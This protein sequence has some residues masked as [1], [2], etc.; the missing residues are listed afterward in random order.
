MF[1]RGPRVR[2]ARALLA[3]RELLAATH[4]ARDVARVRCGRDRE[5]FARIAALGLDTVRSFLLW[6]DFPPEPDASI[7][8]CRSVLPRS[9][10][11]RAAPGFASCPCCAAAARRNVRVPAW[12]QSA[13][14]VRDLYSGPMLDAQ[15]AFARA[16]GAR[17]ASIPPCTRG[18][19]G[20]G[21]RRSRSRRACARAPAITR[22]RSS[23]KRR[24]RSG[25]A[26]SPACSPRRPRSAP[27][28]GRTRR[29]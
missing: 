9:P 15:L 6:D 16:V 23:R 29:I 17:C 2:R 3:G 5:D 4:V 10:M 11:P 18:T 7:R 14:G 20:I 27:R 1:E 26:A 24:S 8:R 19:S 13:R 25:A 21:S 12:A 22:R 28:R